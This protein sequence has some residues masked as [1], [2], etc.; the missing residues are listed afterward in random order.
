MLLKEGVFT[1]RQL[2]WEI[3]WCTVLAMIADQGR[4]VG[5]KP[6][7]N[8]IESEEEELAFFGL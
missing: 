5:R 4:I 7:E 8:I 2:M 3:P 1:Y 6:E